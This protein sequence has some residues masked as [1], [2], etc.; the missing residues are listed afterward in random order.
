MNDGDIAETDYPFWAV[1]ECGK[2]KFVD[3]A[4]RTV[5]A[6]RA[7]DGADG[8]IIQHLLQVFC[9]FFICS[10][11]NKIFFSN[12]VAYAYLKAPVLHLLNCG[13]NVLFC[14]VTSRTGNAYRVS[15]L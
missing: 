3:N 1:N 13:L 2:I 11:E 4:D 12:G 10:A 8:M 6:A 15:I 7:H 9:A 5:T 14:D